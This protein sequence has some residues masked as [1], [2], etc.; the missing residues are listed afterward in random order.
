MEI[1]R[2]AL[3]RA[4]QMR[5]CLALS[6]RFHLPFTTVLADVTGL[7]EVGVTFTALACEF[8]AVLRI[9]HF[10]ERVPTC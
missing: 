7:R 6:R 5:H 9:F 1:R 4:V 2:K 10:F 8:M 3:S